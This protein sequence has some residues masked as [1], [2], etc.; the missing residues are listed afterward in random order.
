MHK[1]GYTVAFIM[2]L[3]L[4]L[5]VSC[6][7]FN[8]YYNARKSYREALELAKQH[9]DNPVSSE[10]VL[11]DEAIAGAAKILAIYPE[12]KWVDDAQLLLG[13][14]LLQL[15]RRTL[16]GSG[17]S[18]LTEAMMAFSSTAI[19]TDDQTIRDR[20]FTGMGLAAMELG[21]L[22][23]AVASFEN[24]SHE[25][26]ERYISSRLYLMNAQL[27]NNQPEL[28]LMVA[29]SLGTPRDDS[30]SAE[31]KLLTSRALMEIGLPDSGA[32]M[33]LTAGDM[34]RRGKGYYRALTIAAE[35]YLQADKP[36]KAVEILTQL[37]SGYR[38]D[39]ET[40]TIAL[41]DGKARE[42]AGDPAGA[43]ASF[44]SAADLDSYQQ[45]GAEALYLRAILLEKDGRIEDALDNL[46]EL[47]GRSGDYLWLRLAED[48]RNDLELLLDYSDELGGCGESESW[49]YRLMIAEKRI[50]LYGKDDSEALS[51]LITISEIA[52]DMER[53]MA[54]AALS[55]IMIIDVDSSRVLLLK[56]YALCDRGDLA[57]TIEDRLNVD[58]GDGYRFRPS[59][60][61][62]HAWNLL[63]EEKFNEAWEELN[64][65][66]SSGWSRMKR[67]EILWAAYLAA[68]GARMD[69]KI[70]EEYLMELSS[71]Y[72]N[73]ELG[74]AALNRLGGSEEGGEEE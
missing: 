19:L 63:G 24:V 58:R 37:L 33:A 15:G 68:E 35:A 3:T 11:L 21:R 30:L 72:G 32:V 10:E 74:I 12:S 49:L 2:V 27:L 18:D 23:D 55:D 31:L 16:T 71:E 17:T 56:A 8:T 66:L 6:A 14:A 48:R 28:A 29:D 39:L 59:V 42:L 34:F 4:L 1:S 64:T 40:A 73:T 43:M 67:P 5:V 62:E 70:L 69:D 13:N 54:L 36:G 61:L 20:A 47:S 46:E 44:R 57:T 53:A 22:N 7:Y 26:D 52:P 60:I 38:S 25:N 45:Y 41:L 65:A 50:D 51:E 9:P